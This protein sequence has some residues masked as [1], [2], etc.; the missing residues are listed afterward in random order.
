MGGLV[1]EGVSEVVKSDDTSI[2]EESILS[3]V[4]NDV[5]TVVSMNGDVLASEV[6][7]I[8]EDVMFVCKDGEVMMSAEGLYEEEADGD[9]NGLA[10]E[11][12]SELRG[13]AVIE[14]D[15][16]VAS[17]EEDVACDE[18]EPADSK[19]EDE[20]IIGVTASVTDVVEGS[21]IK[22]SVDAR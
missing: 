20:T 3:E 4:E 13:A 8:C 18:L 6:T 16:R 12:T 22:L 17:E 19:T 11:D 5:C 10:L 15:V 7:V 2:C 1:P 21:K 14:S 9:V